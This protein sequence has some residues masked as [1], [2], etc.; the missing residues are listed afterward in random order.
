MFSASTADPNAVYYLRMLTSK[1][2]TR[3]LVMMAGHISPIGASTKTNFTGTPL[4]AYFSKYG[5]SSFKLTTD[6]LIAGEYALGRPYGGAVFC[7]GVD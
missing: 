2:K 6:K 4:P 7:F 1:K 5:S 3:E